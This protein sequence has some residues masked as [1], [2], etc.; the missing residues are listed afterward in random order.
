VGDRRN[1]NPHHKSVIAEFLNL[2]AL[3]A[4]II[5]LSA[6]DSESDQA[7]VRAAS[8]G[9][10]QRLAN[11][12]D[13]GA[14]IE[15]SAFEGWTP[16]NAA[17][18]KG[19]FGVVELLVERGAKINRTDASQCSAVG[20]AADFGY[21]EV[22]SYLLDAG[23]NLKVCS[24][25]SWRYTL[26]RLR[27][28]GET[29]IETRFREHGLTL[30]DM[31]SAE[32][33]A[34]SDKNEEVISAILA[35]D[36]AS[37]DTLLN[38]GAK[39]DAMEGAYHT[40]LIAAVEAGNRKAAV[41]LL[42]VGASIDLVNGYHQ[43]PLQRAVAFENPEMVEFLL[44]RG[45]DPNEGDPGKWRMR[46]RQLEQEDEHEIIEVLNQHGWDPARPQCEP[47]IWMWTPPSTHEFSMH[48]DRSW[49]WG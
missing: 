29:E 20:W 5:F 17:A 7:V 35:H 40:P 26:R 11:L 24:D 3:I 41:R 19:H 9:E 14:D 49:P 43:T 21:A 18:S 34:R 16:L 25:R 22:V 1:S 27:K 4:L 36:H 47:A 15:A 32:R 10:T 38:L 48:G 46:K 2:A 12:L 13:G 45:A 31:T 37:M 28:N 42:E 44:Q 33:F 39:V 23:A 6:C 8:R 30:E